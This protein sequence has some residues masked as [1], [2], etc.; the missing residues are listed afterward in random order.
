MKQLKRPRV[1]WLA[2]VGALVVGLG[3]TI[4]GPAWAEAR[5]APGTTQRHTYTNAA[6]TRQYLLATPPA[7]FVGRRPLVV[8]LHG[9]TQTADDAATQTRFTQLGAAEGFY[10]IY[11]EQDAH[12]NGG[13]C[14]NW[15]LPGDQSRDAGEPSIIADITRHVA[16][17]YRVDAARMYVDG[18][19][20]GAAMSV[21]MGATYPELYA[22]I[23][24][25]AGCE[26]RGLP[27]VGSASVVPP[28][29]AGQWAF[30]AM[31]PR[32]RVMPVFAEVGDLDLVAPAPNTE[33][34]VQQ[35]LATDDI[36]DDIGGDG[37]IATTPASTTHGQV[38]NGYSYDV[39]HYR[40]GTCPLIERWLTHGMGHAYPGGTAG[41]PYSDPKGPDVTVAAWHFFSQFSQAR[42]RGC[43]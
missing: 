31:G 36:A 34:V 30:Q 8:V 9:C 38:P 43:V 18:L 17:A 20:A 35:W 37:S 33:Q 26:Y 12:A 11:P 13:R 24:V 3:L 22:A 14:W 32:A 2:L 15:F 25:I 41:V 6:G 21:V 40:D 1:A 19:S 16:A 5:Q 7:R 39:D 28:T 42:P 4:G 23:G 27:C 29:T 10:V